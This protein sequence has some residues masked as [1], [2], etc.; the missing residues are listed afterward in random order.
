VLPTD[1]RGRVDGRPS[2]ALAEVEI[3]A[4]LVEDLP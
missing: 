4:R 2:V 3:E 1:V